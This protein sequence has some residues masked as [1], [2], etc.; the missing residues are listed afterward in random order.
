M[1]NYH[2]VTIPL[3]AIDGDILSDIVFSNGGLGLEEK[4]VVYICSFENGFDKDRLFSELSNFLDPDQVVI[5]TKEKQNWMESWKANFKPLEIGKRF[6]VKPSW[7]ADSDSQRIEIQ[8]D[9]KMAFGT[10]THETTQLILEQLEDIVKQSDTVL[11][12]GTGSGILAIAAEKL[13]AAK[14]IAFD[15]D[16]VAIENCEENLQLNHCKNV[17]AFAGEIESISEQFDVVIANINRNILIEIATQLIATCKKD[18]TLV[19]SGL[20]LEDKPAILKAYEHVKLA[21][22]VDKGEWT[23]LVFKLN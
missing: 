5:E 18:G 23:C 12:A 19:L 14:V 9:P 22:S 2:T 1:S 11:D 16:P 8:I 10:G 13:G 6:L 3:T 4:E 20:L 17:S 21:K 7:I 15:N